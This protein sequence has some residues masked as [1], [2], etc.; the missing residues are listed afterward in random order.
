MIVDAN[1]NFVSNLEMRVRPGGEKEFSLPVVC[2][3]GFTLKAE[4]ISLVSIDAKAAPG[5]S[6]SDLTANPVDLSPFAGQTKTF[7]FRVS[8]DNAAPEQIENIFLIVE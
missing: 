5:D 1:N 7:Y 4:T 8:V 2:Q 6:Y 3:A